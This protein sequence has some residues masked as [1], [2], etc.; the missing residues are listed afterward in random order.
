MNPRTAEEEPAPLLKLVQQEQV[1]KILDAVAHLPEP[2]REVFV[3]RFV[4]DE[5]YETIALKVNKTVQQVRGLCHRAIVRVKTLVDLK[6]L[7]SG[8]Y[9]YG[10]D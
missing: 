6:P 2:L 1:E 7:P 8:E 4:Q 9:A 10:G 5:T 3:L